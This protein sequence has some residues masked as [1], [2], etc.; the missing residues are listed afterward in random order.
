MLPKASRG[1]DRNKV[2][3]SKWGFYFKGDGEK[4]QN[5][6]QSLRAAASTQ[7]ARVPGGPN[8]PLVLE[9]VSRNKV[10]VAWPLG[11]SA[12]TCSRLLK[13]AL[14]DSWRKFVTDLAGVQGTSTEEAE[15]RQGLKQPRREMLQHRPPRACWRHSM[16]RC[17]VPPSAA[18]R[19]VQ[20]RIRCRRGPRLLVTRGSERWARA[21]QQPRP[22]AVASC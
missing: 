14:C 20:P 18:Q 9:K 2:K 4:P 8:Q 22:A 1:R 11:V 3:F 5:S 16:W 10:E 13:R 12:D 15:K 17:L 6:M 21:M 19:L 7:K